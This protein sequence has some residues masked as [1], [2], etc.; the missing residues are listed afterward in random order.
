MNAQ[1]FFL[2]HWGNLLWDSLGQEILPLA[3]GEGNA[4]SHQFPIKINYDAS[5]KTM[6]ILNVVQSLSCGP[7]LCDPVDYS[8]A[9]SSVL[10]YLLGLLKFVF[11]ESVMLSN[12]LIFCHPLSILPSIFSNIRIFSNESS[13][14]KRGGQSTGASTSAPV[15]PMNIPCQFPLCNIYYWLWELS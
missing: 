6:N 13:R 7:N 8:T 5:L 12:H 9:S 14:L 15:L 1:A 3:R 4:I 2:S 10:Y 11:I